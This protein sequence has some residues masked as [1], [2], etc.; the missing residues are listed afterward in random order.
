MFA[1]AYAANYPLKVA[2]D[3]SHYAWITL[4]YAYT[5]HG[6]NIEHAFCLHPFEVWKGSVTYDTPEL[7][8]ELKVRAEVK[9][10]DCRTGNFKDVYNRLNIPTNYHPYPYLGAYLN[11]RKGVYGIAMRASVLPQ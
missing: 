6:G 2:N 10:G 9:V 7:G 1:P 11:E 4:Y 5:I 3:T 8:P